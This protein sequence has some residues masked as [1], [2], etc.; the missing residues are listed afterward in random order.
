MLVDVKAS[1]I[2]TSPLAPNNPAGDWPIRLRIDQSY[3][4]LQKILECEG[5]IKASELQAVMMMPGVLASDDSAVPQFVK[6]LMDRK[7]VEIRRLDI[8]DSGIEML[9]DLASNFVL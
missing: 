4:A 1:I 9:S 7:Q 3:G 5:R 6:N 2:E 8:S